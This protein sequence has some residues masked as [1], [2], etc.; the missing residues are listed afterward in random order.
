MVSPSPDGHNWKGSSGARSLPRLSEL[1]PAELRAR[2]EKLSLMADGATTQHVQ[3]A[4]R[5]LS[6]KFR[7]HAANRKAR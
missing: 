3:T 5:R 6:E 1:S 4:L 7:Q 2:A